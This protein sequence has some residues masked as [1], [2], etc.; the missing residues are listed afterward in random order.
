MATAG[1]PCWRLDGQAFLGLPWRVRLPD[2][3]TRTDPDQWSAD[4]AVLAATGWRESTLTDDDIAAMLPPEPAQPTPAAPREPTALELGY[5]TQ[6]GWRLGWQPD[7]VALLTGL[8]VLGQRAEQLGVQQP[9]TVT[10]TAGVGHSLTFA[11]FDS[12]ML[13]YGAARAALSQSLAAPDNGTV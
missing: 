9:I 11:E 2:G 1:D 8:Y 10:D 6:E 3:T 7:D 5:E 4:P 13:G 12:V